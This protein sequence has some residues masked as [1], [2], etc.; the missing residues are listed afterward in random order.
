MRNAYRRVALSNMVAQPIQLGPLAAVH[1]DADQVG[2][3]VTVFEGFGPARRECLPH[4]AMTTSTKRL[5]LEGIATF[6]V[7]GERIEVNVASPCSY[8]AG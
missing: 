2:G 5:R 3:S 1:V 6:N 4:I 8:G 7:G